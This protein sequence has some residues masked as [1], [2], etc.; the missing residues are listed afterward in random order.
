VVLAEEVRM[1]LKGILLHLKIV[2]QWFGGGERFGM[3]L[4]ENAILYAF[5]INGL[6]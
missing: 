5:K 6:L 3:I 1:I 2:I 4:M